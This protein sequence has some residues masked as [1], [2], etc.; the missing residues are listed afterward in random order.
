MEVGP[1]KLV[2]NFSA[3]RDVS[4]ET[5]TLSFPLS[6]FLLVPSSAHLWERLQ[7]TLGGHGALLGCGLEN[8]P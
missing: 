3:L 2:Q 4:Q 6:S 5:D 7:I 1:E 8:T